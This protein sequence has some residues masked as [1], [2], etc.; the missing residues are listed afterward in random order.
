M[1]TTRFARISAVAATAAVLAAAAFAAPA[2]ADDPADPL[3]LGHLQADIT[4]GSTPTLVITEGVGI[5]TNWYSTLSTNPGQTCPVGTTRSDLRAYLDGALLPDVVG[6]A[7]RATMPE[8]EGL[9]IIVGSD[10]IYRA[11]GYAY[12]YS[13]STP[14][15]QVVDGGIIEIR[16][17]C[18]T[19]SVYNSATDPYYSIVFEMAAGGAWHVVEDAAQADITVV[20]PQA[21]TPPALPEGLKL[22]AKPD[23]TTLTSAATRAAGQV[24]NV[25][26]TLSP[27]RVDDDRQDSDAP[28]WTLTGKVSDFSDGGTN[29]IAATELGWTPS[30]TAG[31]GTAGSAVAPGASGGLS[32]P[33]T[34]ATGEASDTAHVT[35]DLEAELSLD[36][37]ASAPA[38]TYTATLTLTLV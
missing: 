37:P 17:T 11:D 18:Q 26:G 12:F 15:E 30:K 16:H 29:T 31:D 20:V 3:W 19:S 7:I 33:K 22:T 34:F 4:S 25:T 24:W 27:T 5:W 13:S 21:Q 6:G 28:D 10:H 36:V 9:D 14:R 38:A 35:T 1:R 23:P 8:P 32:T 2:H